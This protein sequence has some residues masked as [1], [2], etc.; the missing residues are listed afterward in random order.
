[1]PRR[2]TSV[3]EIR[4]F[5]LQDITIFNLK[6]ERLSLFKQPAETGQRLVA[7]I[8]DPSPAQFEQCCEENRKTVPC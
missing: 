1:M 4:L 3:F 6:R 2:L 5:L 7:E 8:F